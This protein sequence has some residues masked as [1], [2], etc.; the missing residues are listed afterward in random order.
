MLGRAVLVA[1]LIWPGAVLGQGPAEDPSAPPR[2]ADAWY[3]IQ[4]SFEGPYVAVS[5]SRTS[6]GWT[7]RRVVIVDDV[8]KAV[9]PEQPGIETVTQTRCPALAGVVDALEPLMAVRLDIAGAATDS[10]SNPPPLDGWSITVGGRGV[11]AGGGHAAMTLDG[12]AD[13]PAAA[14][15]LRTEAALSDCWSP[16]PEPR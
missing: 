6:D 3:S 13:I 7:A 12:N 11:L 14:W 1:A 15:A 9:W 10:P 5:F 4:P 16:P 2:H 8:G